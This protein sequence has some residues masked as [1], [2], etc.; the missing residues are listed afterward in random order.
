MTWDVPTAED[1][2]ECGQTLFKKAGKGRNKPFCINENC[3]KFLPEDQRG[4]YKKKTAENAE[5]A[6][7][8]EEP[9]EKP[10]K[11]AAKKAAKT[12]AKKT[13]TKKTTTKKTTAKKKEA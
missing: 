2:P 1:C 8:T 3:S 4:Y 6:E 5:T 7:S 13:S 9:E 11:T 10:K 12:A